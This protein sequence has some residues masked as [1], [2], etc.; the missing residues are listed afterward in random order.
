MVL[1]KESLQVALMGVAGLV[2]LNLDIFSR[3][4][5]TVCVRLDED[6]VG[7]L[8]GGTIVRSNSFRSSLG[9]VCCTLARPAN[10]PA[11]TSFIWS[12][13]SVDLKLFLFLTKRKKKKMSFFFLFFFKHK[14]VWERNQFLNNKLKVFYMF[15]SGKY[16]DWIHYVKLGVCL[17]ALASL[18]L[19]LLLCYKCVFAK[20]L[21][22]L[23]YF[24]ISNFLTKR[25]HKI[26]EMV[27]KVVQC[28]QTNN[29][30]AHL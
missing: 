6:E 12:F 26:H 19:L 4:C 22:W 3:P 8:S 21:F 23:I 5:L 29:N 1:N 24:Y 25:R 17:G 16:R 13:K 15:D 9:N 11:H 20:H 10:L 27:F 7:A 18:L 14:I 28:M 2:K 30:Q